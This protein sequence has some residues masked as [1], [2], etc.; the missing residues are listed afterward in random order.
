MSH[1]HGG[2]SKYLPTFAMMKA[3]FA[4]TVGTTD[5]ESGHWDVRQEAVY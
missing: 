4:G 3:V 1:I 2:T 5:E